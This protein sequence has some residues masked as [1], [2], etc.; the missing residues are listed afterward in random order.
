MLKELII[1]RTRGLCNSPV[2]VVPNKGQNEDGTL[3]HR[4]VIDY[5]K[6]KQKHNT[7]Q[8]PDEIPVCNI[9]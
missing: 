8:I 9:I 7:G 6:T 3:K 2:V 5:K 4:L 1:R